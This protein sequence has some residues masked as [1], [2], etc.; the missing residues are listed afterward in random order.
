MDINIQFISYLVGGGTFLFLAVLVGLSPTGGRFKRILL[1]A[2]ALTVLWAF[3]VAA[4]QWVAGTVWGT[5]WTSVVSTLDVLRNV[6]WLVLLGA[7]LGIRR[8]RDAGS[9]SRIAAAAVLLVS[10]GLIFAEPVSAFLW[11]ERPRELLTFYSGGRVILAVVGLLALVNLYRN[12][13]PRM[14]WAI[15]Y[16]L[17]PLTGSIC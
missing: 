6:A 9:T 3:S 10:L 14:R 4:F 13:D 16:D 17:P 2:C 12:A 1:V 8:I 15:K 5:S 7:L 11:S